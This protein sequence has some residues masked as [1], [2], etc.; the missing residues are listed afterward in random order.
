MFTLLVSAFCIPVC[1]ISALG[2]RK[3]ITMVG[4][5]EVDWSIESLVNLT[6]FQKRPCFENLLKFRA[7]IEN[8]YRIYA[9]TISV[10]KIFLNNHSARDVAFLMI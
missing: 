8:C 6:S 1:K 10:K 9:H 7:W 5:C 3:E 2:K 4:A